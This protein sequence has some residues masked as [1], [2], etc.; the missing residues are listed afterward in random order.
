MCGAATKLHEWA[1]PALCVCVLRFHYKLFIVQI[2]FYPIREECSLLH[3]KMTINSSLYP[4]M[5]TS[6]L[7]DVAQPL[8]TRMLSQFFFSFKFHW[9]GH[10]HFFFFLHW[11]R[12]HLLLSSPFT[13]NAMQKYVCM[14]ERCRLLFALPWSALSSDI[15]IGVQHT[16]TH[17]FYKNILSQL[18]RCCVRLSSRLM[19]YSWLMDVTSW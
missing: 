7:L 12:Y 17:I 4:A 8:V 16:V 10:R 13:F 15:S 11:W 2:I 1:K 5:H 9:T 19:K 18:E 14:I 6:R 3:V